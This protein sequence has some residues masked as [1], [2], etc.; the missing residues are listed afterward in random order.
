M[1]KVLARSLANTPSPSKSFSAMERNFLV[2]SRVFKRKSDIPDKLPAHEYKRINDK[3]RSR[4][5]L[6]VILTSCVGLLTVIAMNK[7]K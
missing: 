7:N 1:I 6:S 5:G 2:I 4:L 3:A